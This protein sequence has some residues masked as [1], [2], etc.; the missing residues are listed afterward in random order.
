MLNFRLAALAAADFLSQRQP[1]ILPKPIPGTRVTSSMAS[2]WLRDCAHRAIWS[3]P[4]SSAQTPTYRSLPL[5][6][7]PRTSIRIGSRTSYLIRHP[8][9]P[10]LPLSR[11]AADD[12]ATYIASLKK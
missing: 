7:S 12:I 4:T 11:T 2:T 10:E 8:K 1:G 5:S 3:R 6:R 9:M